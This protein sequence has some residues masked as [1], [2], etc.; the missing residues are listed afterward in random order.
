[1]EDRPGPE[2]LIQGCIGHGVE[3]SRQIPSAADDLE[4]FE[5][6]MCSADVRPCAGV[7]VPLIE[8]QPVSDTPSHS[9]AD[10]TRCTIE[11]ALATIDHPENKLVRRSDIYL[12]GDRGLRYFRDQPSQ[13]LANQPVRTCRCGGLLLFEGRG[14]PG[15][16][17]N[18]R[19]FRRTSIERFSE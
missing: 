2:Q 10:R 14:Q 6:D 9:R 16:A 8:K 18:N 5:H 19:R 15:R 4:F 12:V 3:G 11:G 7:G 17:R 13:G 1:M